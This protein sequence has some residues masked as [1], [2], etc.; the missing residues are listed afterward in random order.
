MALEGT[1]IRLAVDLKEECHISDLAKYISGTIYPDSRYITQIDRK[2][3]HPDDFLNDDFFKADDFRKGWFIHLLCDN[4]QRKL[5]T[6]IFSDIASDDKL[7]HGNESWIVRSVLKILQD[8]DDVKKFDI[9]NYLPLLDYAENPNGESLEKVRDYNQFFQKMYQSSP[10]IEDCCQMWKYLG[11]SDGLVNEM[12]KK[13][14]EYSNNKNIIERTNQI[15][16]EILNKAREAVR[17][18]F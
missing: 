14:E 2:L 13:L 4:I 9:K 11:V 6:K 3:T 7:T 17:N 12:K 15:Y 5:Q 1:H 8:M 16:S 18:K 10:E